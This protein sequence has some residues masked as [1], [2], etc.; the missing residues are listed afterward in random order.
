MSNVFKFGEIYLWLRDCE[1]VGNECDEEEINNECTQ[2]TSEKQDDKVDDNVVYAE[3]GD[4]ENWGDVQKCSPCSSLLAVQDDSSF[5]TMSIPEKSE[6]ELWIDRPLAMDVGA[7][8]GMLN[9]MGAGMAAGML[10]PMTMQEPPCRYHPS[11][12]GF[13][14]LCCR[15]KEEQQ[16]K[17]VEFEAFLKSESTQVPFCDICGVN[18]KDSCYMTIH[19][20]WHDER[21]EQC[22]KQEDCDIKSKYDF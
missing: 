3:P 21:C 14:E 7:G 20:H 6:C 4:E 16:R 11:V 18:V 19:K 17:T 2:Y 15:E 22:K 1:N 5:D 12:E 9:S 13:K 10:S 8:V